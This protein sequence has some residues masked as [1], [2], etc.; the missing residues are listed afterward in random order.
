MAGDA[1]RRSNLGVPV[2]QLVEVSLL[3]VVLVGAT[4]VGELGVIP[5]GIVCA[6]V[7]LF[8]SLTLMYS[9]FVWRQRIAGEVR[10]A[11]TAAMEGIKS[12]LRNLH[13]VQES[14]AR[15]AN[16][17]RAAAGGRDGAS[18]LAMESIGDADLFEHERHER[19][20]E[21]VVCK[22]D[23]GTEFED[24]LAEKDS[25][26]NFAD[27]VKENLA[28]DRP[29]KYVWI[30]LR[31]PLT[32]ERAN[33]IHTALGPQTGHYAI[34]LLEAS[35]WE[36][37]PSPF[38]TVCYRHANQTLEVFTLAPTSGAAMDRRWLS[39]PKED[40]PTWRSRLATVEKDERIQPFA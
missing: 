7:L 2:R 39:V 11:V 36:R 34:Y 29:V 23:M 5:V 30:A 27:L 13:D 4:A 21:V 15:A 17:V 40:R 22:R 8:I 14:L 3:L 28:R 37:M 35:D 38:E 25:V 31:S 33:Q 26:L 20:T 32:E 6:I 12:D 1:E 16:E 24:T 9:S 10:G 19:L 18:L